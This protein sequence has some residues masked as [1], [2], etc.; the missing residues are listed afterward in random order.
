MAFLKG[1]SCFLRVGLQRV[2]VVF[3]DHTHSLLDLPLQKYDIQCSPFITDLIITQIWIQHGHVV[4][5]NFFYPTL[6]CYKILKK[7]II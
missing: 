5:P 2:I 1:L 6:L 3:S 7:I 4:V